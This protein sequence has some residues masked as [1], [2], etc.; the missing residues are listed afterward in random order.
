[1]ASK[2]EW[3]LQHRAW[4]TP[5]LPPTAGPGRTVHLENGA[6]HVLSGAVAHAAQIV[7]LVGGLHGRE[8]QHPTPHH[9]SGG[10]D[11]VLP[12]CRREGQRHGQ[13]AS[14]PRA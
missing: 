7:R 14:L 1:M 8:A 10:Q 3:C 5:H 2:V 9:G 13:G 4:P 12:A 11:T 6:G